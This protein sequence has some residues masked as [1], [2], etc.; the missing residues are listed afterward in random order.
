H[1]KRNNRNRRSR[2][3]SRSRRKSVSPK[4]PLVPVLEQQR[5]EHRNRR[6]EH[7]R[8][9]TTSR[10]LLSSTTSDVRSSAP[11]RG[12]LRRQDSHNTTAQPGA[13]HD[14]QQPLQL[15]LN[16]G[17]GEGQNGGGGRMV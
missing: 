3:F 9:T 7:E 5:Q 16:G 11:N 12:P 13:R 17:P 4:N 10:N 6:R 14:N 15:P 8:V 2:S 1:V